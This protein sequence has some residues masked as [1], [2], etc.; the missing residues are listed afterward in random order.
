[1]I[2]MKTRILSIV[3]LAIILTAGSV[4]AQRGDFRRD[5][6]SMPERRGAMMKQRMEN[7]DARFTQEQRDFMQKSRLETEKRLKPHH[8][9]M[10]ELRARH[11][12]L[13]TADKADMKAIATSLEKIAEVQLAMAMIRTEQH[14]QLRAQ[15]T[16]EQ[17]MIFDKRG[18]MIN[19]PGRQ[20]QHRGR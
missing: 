19:M 15:L 4:N 10:R 1:M 11:Q 20:K 5:G 12:T 8:D 18:H 17:R 9:Q 7:P 2:I 3:L 14:Q 13:V 16:D 6:K